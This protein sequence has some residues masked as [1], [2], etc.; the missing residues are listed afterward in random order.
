M[1]RTTDVLTSDRQISRPHFSYA[2]F[3]GGWAS[4]PMLRTALSFH[5]GFLSLMSIDLSVRISPL[6]SLIRKHFW[7]VYLCFPDGLRAEERTAILF[8]LL[9]S[10]GAVL[11]FRKPQKDPQL[12]P[13]GWTFDRR[14]LR[15]NRAELISDSSKES[16]PLRSQPYCRAEPPPFQQLFAEA[17]KSAG[18]EVSVQ[19]DSSASLHPPLSACAPPSVAVLPAGSWRSW[20]SL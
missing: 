8:G 17:N 10:I 18:K 6:P 14:F 15:P 7:T 20:R 3:S 5:L 16:P 19:N 4:A 9:V 13:T 2:Q 12:L 1:R 11:G